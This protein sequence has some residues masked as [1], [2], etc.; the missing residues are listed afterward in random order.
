MYWSL[1]PVVL[2]SGCT[3][4][5]A[6][7]FLLD[8]ERKYES[9]VNEGAMDAAPYDI[10]LAHEY[11]WKAREEANDSDY[12]ATE[13]LCKKSAAYSATALQKSQDGPDI[14]NAGEFVPEERVEKPV[15]DNSNEPKIDLDDL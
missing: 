14:K 11:L 13:Q 8:A 9:A 2:L 15:E 3:A 6:S 10:T 1:L 4:A 7:Y 5:R 12:G